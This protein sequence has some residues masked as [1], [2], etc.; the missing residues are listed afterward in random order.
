M[1]FKLATKLSSDS[2]LSHL[3]DIAAQN[4]VVGLNYAGEVSPRCAFNYASANKSVIV[5]VRTAAE[6]QF[7]GIPDLSSTLGRLLTLSW[8]LYPSFDLN[9]GFIDS[10]I[11]ETSLTKDTPLFF[12]CRSGGR[13]LDAALAVTEEG[14][15]YCFNITGGFEGD[16]DAKGHRNTGN[17]WKY[18]NLP[19]VQG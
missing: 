16:V 15:N 13:S 3:V 11:A 17:G 6:W 14:Y 12:M 7:V 8:K 2:T 9:P 4:K 5:D 1:A 18:E 10:L 19:W